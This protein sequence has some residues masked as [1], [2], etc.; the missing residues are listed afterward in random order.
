T[1][2]G[3]N[4]K[5]RAPLREGLDLLRDGL[6]EIFERECRLFFDSPW[7]VRDRYVE[8]F[9]RGDT[10]LTSDFIRKSASRELSG[11]ETSRAAEL[12]ESQRNAMYMFTSCGWFFNDISGI[13]AVQLLRYAA[14][15][16]E[17]T[18][19][20]CGMSL[21][22]GELPQDTGLARLVEDFLEVLEKA[23][24]NIP[25]QGNGRE[26]YSGA[27]KYASVEPSLLAGQYALAANLGC[28]EASPERFGMVF[29][30]HE[31]KHIEP[32]AA[33]FVI[34][35]FRMSD[36]LTLTHLDYQYL[37]L[38]DDPS[39]V[40]CMLREF[41]GEEQFA[42]TVAEFGKTGAEATRSDVIKSAT[43]KFGG[44]IFA[45]RDLFPEDKEKILGILARRQIG[46]AMGLFR[47]LYATNRELLRL[48]NETSLSPPESLLGPARTVL[49]AKLRSE[50]DGWNRT[51]DDSG[52]E[53]VHNVISE[54]KYY[55]VEIDQTEIMTLFE[56]FLLESLARM[57]GGISSDLCERLH[58]FT[59][60]AYGIEIDI[61]QHEIQNELFRMM[62]T[63]VEEVIRRIETGRGFSS[64]LAAVTCFLRLARRFNFNTDSWQERLPKE[65]GD[66]V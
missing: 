4:Q 57:E 11:E 31:Q 51:L 42:A 16:V 44:R 47:E 45:M 36:P 15:A 5:W 41:S 61:P 53:G 3:W 10:G 52:L 59:E 55:G 27:R 56:E 62:T 39:R 18:A 9:G 54:A 58:L 60:Y 30:G 1:P 17:M 34:G 48:F 26:I 64:D 38:P 35:R 14:R 21:S 25:G 63:R 8:V 7:E 13:E 33:S 66:I 43:E 12:L 49:S 32:G 20:G 28:P 2:A 24:S 23:A 19:R 46:S 6:A 65:P 22:G 50:I 37:L 29:S 40:T